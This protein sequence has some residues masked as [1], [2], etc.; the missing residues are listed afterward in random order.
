MWG[1]LLK[2]T[3]EGRHRVAEVVRGEMGVPEGHLDVPVPQDLS[4]G[5]QGNAFLHEERCEGVPIMPIS[6]LAPLCRVPD[7]AAPPR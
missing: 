3:V 1:L 4:N 7:Y 2:E 6:A 5:V